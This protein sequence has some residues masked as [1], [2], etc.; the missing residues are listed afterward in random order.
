MSAYGPVDCKKLRLPAC[1]PRRTFHSPKL[2][3]SVISRDVVLGTCRAHSGNPR[4]LRSALWC[5]RS[6]AGSS[7][8]IARRASA[9]RDTIN[10]R[11]SASPPR[12]DVVAG[13]FYLRMGGF[14]LRRQYRVFD[15]QDDLP[16][17]DYPLRRENWSH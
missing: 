10:L 8:R 4:A 17:N 2:Y 12:R 1:D 14:G 11:I 6:F 9:W 7:V 13:P 15:R 3:I 5:I 16:S